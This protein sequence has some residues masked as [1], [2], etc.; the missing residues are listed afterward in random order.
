MTVDN[1]ITPM[2]HVSKKSCDPQYRPHPTWMNGE[3]KNMEASFALC[4]G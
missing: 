2:F 4:I 1:R 3:I